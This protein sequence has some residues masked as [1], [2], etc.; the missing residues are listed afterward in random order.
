[1][2][3]VESLSSTEPE[4]LSLVFRYNDTMSRRNLLIIV[5]TIFSTVLTV[6][7]I[8]LLSTES[9]STM[10]SQF[11]TNGL[12]NGQARS[13]LI[14]PPGYIPLISSITGWLLT[15]YEIFAERRKKISHMI[16]TRISGRSDRW[17]IYEIFK[18][19]GGARRL[20]I[21]ESLDVPRQRNEVAR[22][23]NTDWKE[24]ARNIKILESA[25]LVRV[26]N[27]K[28]SYPSYVLTDQGEELLKGI[29]AV[30]ES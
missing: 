24:V 8:L 22:L 27:T 23:T 17:K 19:K 25:N 16:R 15:G 21:L 29:A 7:T 18:G 5:M 13:V 11:Y 6:Y 14:F 10:S 20:T 9:A 26:S 1:M 30:I 28:T 12:T 3:Y 4:N 2:K